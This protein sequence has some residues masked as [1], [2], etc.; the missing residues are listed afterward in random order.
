MNTYYVYAYLR[1][2]DLTPYY[3]GKGKGR[4]AWAKDHNVRVPDENFRIVI[5]EGNLTNVGACAIERRLIKWYGRK[6]L[7]TGILRNLTDGGDGTVNHKLTE[8]QRKARS[9]ARKGVPQLKLRKPK[10]DITKQR[11]KEAWKT[12]SR[13]IK[14][15]TSQ[16]L[17]AANKIYWSNDESRLKQSQRRRLFLESNPEVMVAQISNLNLARYTCCFCG[18]NTN[19]GNY[20]RWHGNNCRQKIT[21]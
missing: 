1:K 9:V 16:L 13:E 7:G 10:T 8:Q 4:R 14:P 11:M 12:R 17:S 19:K 5:I 15:S 3:I 21:P 18:V 2:S 20:S 6:D